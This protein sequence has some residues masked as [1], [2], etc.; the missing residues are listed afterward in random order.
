[1]LQTHWLREGC[2]GSSGAGGGPGEGRGC[3]LS[4][5]ITVTEENK[6]PR[7]SSA[8]RPGTELHQEVGLDGV[9]G[10]FLPATRASHAFP[11]VT[12]AW[13]AEQPQQDGPAESQ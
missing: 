4:P 8:R 7:P 6:S 11:E 12:L 3:E 2:G 13:R 10:P 1:M 9:V 5:S